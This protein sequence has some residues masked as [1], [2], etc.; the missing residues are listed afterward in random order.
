MIAICRNT[1]TGEIVSFV[2]NF[3]TDEDVKKLINP[4]F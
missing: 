3:K 1:D 2:G 4:C